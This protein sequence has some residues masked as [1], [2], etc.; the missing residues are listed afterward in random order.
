MQPEHAVDGYFRERAFV[1]PLQRIVYR[2]EFKPDAADLVFGSRE[3]VH[4]ERRAGGGK[5]S[6]ERG[7]DESSAVH[8]VSGAPLVRNEESIQKMG[9]NG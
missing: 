1:I 4:R 5:G 9:R 8:G 6:E 3:S 7:F 2:V